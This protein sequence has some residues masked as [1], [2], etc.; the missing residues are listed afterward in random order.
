MVAKEKVSLFEIIPCHSSHIS[1]IKEGEEVI[2]SFP[3]FKQTWISSHLFPKSMNREVRITLEEHGT[4]VWEL[5]DG[6]RTVKEIVDELAV[7][8]HHE[9][10]YES[11]VIKYLLQLHKDKFIKW[12]TA[13]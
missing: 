2:L 11:R 4:A 13:L 9:S 10:G 3:R 6:K 5:I 12:T 1:T 7:H 8:F